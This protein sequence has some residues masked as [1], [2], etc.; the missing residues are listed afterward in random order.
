[1]FREVFEGC[2][3]VFWE[4]FGGSLG[5]LEK[6]FEGIEGCLESEVFGGL[7]E[8]CFG[9]SGFS[10]AVLCCFEMFSRCIELFS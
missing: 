9:G 3:K 6:Y 5:D 10:Q 7:F 8:G 2:L 1:M 4:V